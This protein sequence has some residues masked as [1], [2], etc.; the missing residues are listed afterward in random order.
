MATASVAM[1]PKP[2]KLATFQ[3]IKERT[4]GGAKSPPPTRHAEN[5]QHARKYTHFHYFVKVHFCAKMT[6]RRND[7]LLP[8]KAGLDYDQ[9]P[10]SRWVNN[11][12]AR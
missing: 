7:Y 3:I 10:T 6:D 9:I 12:K 2:L 4:P 11:Y 5:R 8:Q 1:A